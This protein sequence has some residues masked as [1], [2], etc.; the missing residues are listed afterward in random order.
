MPAPL[1]IFTDETLGTK[2]LFARW[3]D[4]D[5]E[6]VVRKF[7]AGGAKFFVM[8]VGNDGYTYG[9]ARVSAEA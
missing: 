1:Y 5:L 8:W 7:H 4:T 3:H 9:V 2:S 6:I